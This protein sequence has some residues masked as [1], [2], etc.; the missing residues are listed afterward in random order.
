MQ[1]IF[2]DSAAALNPRMTAEEIVSELLV[3]SRLYDDRRALKD[4]VTELLTM[5]GLDGLYRTKCPPELSGGQRQRVAI[6]RSIALNPQVIVA[7]EPVASLDVSIQ[8]QI[9]TLFQHLQ[10]QHKFAFLFIAHDLSMVRFLCDRV[11]VMH[12]GRFVEV[13]PTDDLFDAPRHPYTRA[14][15][16][17]TPVPDPMM[18]RHKK[19]VPFSS[20]HSE[21]KA[22]MREISPRHFVLDF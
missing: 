18:E 14:L 13:A 1:I 3:I 17:A 15:L 10:K 20:G 2:Q 16:S 9:M 7:D 19:V 6:A 4:R 12:A 11:G 21:E 22:E 5:V 8:A